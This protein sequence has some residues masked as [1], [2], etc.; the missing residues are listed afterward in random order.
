MGIESHLPASSHSLCCKKPNKRPSH[1]KDITPVYFIRDVCN[2]ESSLLLNSRMV[3]KC[4]VSRN[5][6]WVMQYKFI[7]RIQE[8]NSQWAAIKKTYERRGVS[9]STC[10]KDEQAKRT[11]C[12]DLRQPRP[13][14]LQV[15][16]IKLRWKFPLLVGWLHENHILYISYTVR[17]SQQQYWVIDSATTYL[18]LCCGDRFTDALKTPSVGVVRYRSPKRQLC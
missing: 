11:A 16:C 1:Y 2:L 18:W 3:F 8:L 13:S 5:I 14:R 6:P 7:L 9:R 17:N 4:P 15:V 10:L 12:R